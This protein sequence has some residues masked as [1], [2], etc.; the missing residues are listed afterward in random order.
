[1]PEET[2]AATLDLAFSPDLIDP[3]V[4]AVLPSGYVMR[5]L[6]RSDFDKGYFALLA[7][8]TVVGD[9]SKDAFEERFDYIKR[10]NDTYYPL[11]IEDQN[12][13]KIVGAGTVVVER[14]FLRGLGLVGHIEDIVVDADQ[15]GKKLGLRVIA[16]LTHLSKATGC[17]KVILNCNDDNIAFYEKCGYTKK[18]VEMVLYHVK[19]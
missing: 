10:H 11:V 15:R 18:E 16:A 6:A 13:G 5:P 1:M 17:Y 19:H 12:V 4:Q 14:K 2:R 7:Q 8:L 9:I 3:E